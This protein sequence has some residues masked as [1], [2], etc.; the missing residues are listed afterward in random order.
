MENLL[1]FCCQVRWSYAPQRF[2]TLSSYR[3][4]GLYHSYWIYLSCLCEMLYRWRTFAIFYLPRK[5]VLSTWTLWNLPGNPFWSVFVPFFAPVS[6]RDKLDLKTWK[7]HEG[8]KKKYLACLQTKTTVCYQYVSCSY[9]LAQSIFHQ[10][11]KH[12]VN[13]NWIIPMFCYCHWRS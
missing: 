7:L 9:S 3:K 11:Y 12:L 8:L 10:L 5:L 6:I 13:F 1:Q 2:Q 4:L